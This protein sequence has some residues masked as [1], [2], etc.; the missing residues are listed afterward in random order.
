MCFWLTFKLRHD[1]DAI[2][3]EIDG[4]TVSTRE[5]RRTERYKADFMSTTTAMA[6]PGNP[7]IS[8]LRDYAE[9]TK[10][11]VTTLIVMTAWCGYFFGAHKAGI[12]WLSWGLFHSLIGIGLGSSGTAALNEVMEL[13]VDA[14]MRRTAMRPLP[15][16]RMS[17]LHA[18]IVGMAAAIGGSIYLAVFTNPLTG[19]LTSL[20]SV[21]Y[22]GAYTPLQKISP[23]CTFVGAF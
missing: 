18:A 20:T 9:L 21:V 6:V 5:Y 23:I 19:L 15:A 22:L 16:Q 7:I 3:A 17:V 1:T 2:V 14:R 11:R 8:L 12:S 13:D 10:L 4:V